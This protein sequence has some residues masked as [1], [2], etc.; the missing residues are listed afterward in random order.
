MSIRKFDVATAYLKG[1]LKEEIFMEPPKLFKEI[2]E[3]IVMSE[4]EN[5]ELKM[6]AMN[7]LE[8]LSTADIVCRLNTSLYGLRQAGRTW[9][10]ILDSI[11]KSY[12]AKPTTSDPCLYYMKKGRELILIAKLHPAIPRTVSSS[13]ESICRQNSR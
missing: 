2:L 5:S 6:N 9:H 12:G 4:A 10:S 7:S 3:D 8:K 13:S 1:K 11:L